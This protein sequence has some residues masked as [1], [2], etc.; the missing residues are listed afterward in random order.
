QN[1][2]VERLIGSIRRE[3]LDYVVVLGKALPSSVGELRDLLQR[4]AH[5]PCARRGCSAP[6][7]CADSRAY[8]ISHLARQSPSALHSDDIIGRHRSIFDL[9]RE[10]H[11]PGQS[12]PSTDSLR[13]Q[14]SSSIR[15]AATNASG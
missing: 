10:C 3:W 4:G 2:Y 5:A 15:S 7:T 1:G 6:S 11:P 8:R 9:R 12:L 14:L 13:I